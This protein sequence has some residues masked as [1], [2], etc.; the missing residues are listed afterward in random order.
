MTLACSQ[1]STW[2]GLR[3][4][5]MAEGVVGLDDFHGPSASHSSVL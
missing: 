1:V 5:V 2:Q 4:R 3:K